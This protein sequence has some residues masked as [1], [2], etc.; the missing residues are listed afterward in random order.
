MAQLILKKAA[1]RVYALCFVCGC[2]GYVTFKGDKMTP[3]RCPCCLNH[4][5]K[6]EGP[7]PGREDPILTKE[8]TKAPDWNDHKHKDQRE[9]LQNKIHSG[10]RY[11]GAGGGY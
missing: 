2:G 10:H 6:L 4:S 5:I 1:R 3:D 8:S 11:P 9:R 7:F